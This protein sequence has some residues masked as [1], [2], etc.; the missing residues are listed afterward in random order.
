MTPKIVPLQLLLLSIMAK[1]DKREMDESDEDIDLTFNP[2]ANKKRA[3]ERNNQLSSLW[4]KQG[5]NPKRQKCRR[6][7]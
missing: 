3:L 2:N 4:A 6:T 7:Q 1:S 5:E